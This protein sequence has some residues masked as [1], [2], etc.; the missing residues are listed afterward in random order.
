MKTIRIKLLLQLLVL[1]GLLLISCERDKCESCDD[2][3]SEGLVSFYDFQGTAN[4]FLSNNDGT[5][6][7]VVYLENIPNSSNQVIMLNGFSSYV[8]LRNPFDYERMTLSIWFN[9]GYFENIYDLIYTSDN[10]ALNYGLLNIAIR[11][12]NGVNTLNFNVSGQNVAVEIE[13]NKW[14]HMAVIKNRKEYKYYLNGVLKESGSFDNYLTSDEGSQTAIVG[15]K[16]TFENGYFKGYIDN[17]RIYDKVLSET[18]IKRLF[19][20]LE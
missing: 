10:P 7:N 12:V 16:R 20:C 1:I 18:E 11:D 2:L 13:P 9:A 3:P 17:I 6:Y 4:D 19:E 5:G 8:D 15:C 14:Y